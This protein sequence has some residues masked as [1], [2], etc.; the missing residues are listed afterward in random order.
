MQILL[1]ESSAAAKAVLRGRITEGLRQT[2]IRGLELTECGEDALAQQSW[3]TICGIVIGPSFQATSEITLERVRN[4]FSAGPIALVLD[5]ESFAQHAPV[6]ARKLNAQVYSMGE[7][8]ALVSFLVECEKQHTLIA[9]RKNKSIF[10]VAQFKGGVGTTTVAAALAACWARHGTKTALIDLDDVNPMLT[11]WARVG[12]SKRTA[13]AEHLSFGHIPESRLGD[14]AAKVDGFAGSLAVIGQPEAYNEGFHFKANVIDSA[15]SA[16]EFMHSLISALKSEYEA[17]VLDLSRSWGLA[18]FASLQRCERILLVVDEDHNSIH[19]TIESLRRM[20]KESDDLEEFDLSR[21]IV[22]INAYTGE[23]LPTKKIAELFEESE[24]FGASPSLVT[25]PYSH[26]GAGW[27]GTDR[28]LYELAEPAAQGALG[29]LAYDLLPF[30]I[31]T[32]EQEGRPQGLWPKLR[33]L[34]GSG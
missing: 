27:G 14:I 31:T 34:L 30:R 15:P 9:N 10:G 17:V 20:K 2:K 24:I 3:G 16:A 26:T 1:L 18:T 8:T 21:W 6:L 32:A 25:I 23:R 5:E 13:V 11:A 19:R 12:V 28:T 7:L 22:V 33:A 4:Y 29:Q